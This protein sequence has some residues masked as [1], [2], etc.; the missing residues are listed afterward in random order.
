MYMGGE[1]NLKQGV[2]GACASAWRPVHAGASALSN[3]PATRYPA[4]VFSISSLG[5]RVHGSGF[6]IEGL[7]SK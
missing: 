1:A 6:R 3:G 5:L 2:D 7:M 4:S